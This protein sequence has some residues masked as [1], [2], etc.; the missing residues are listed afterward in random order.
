MISSKEI[1]VVIQ[2]A[3]DKKITP[4]CLKSIRKFLPEAEIILSTWE[5]SDVEGLDY[6]ILV[7]NQDP[8]GY[9]H[10]F[11]IYNAPHH[12]MNNFNRQLVS[13]LN[14]IKKVNR[15]YILKLRTDLI[16]TNSK[17]LSYWDLFE[18]RNSKYAVFN[19][20]VICSSIYSRENSCQSGTGFPTPFHPSDFWF[21]GLAKDLTEYFIN[22]QLQTETEAS[23]WNFKY[24]TRCPYI[25]QLWR[26]SPEQYFC[27]NWVKKYY[28]DLQFE[29]W[30]DWNPQNIELSKNILYNNFVFLGYE[31]SGIYS[32]KHFG[33]ERI[34][35]SIQGLI[36]YELF[37][38]RYKEYCDN[39][40]VVSK[41]LSSSY[42]K[43]KK[44]F[45]KLITPFSKIYTWIG[46]I[47]SVLFYLFVCVSQLL[48][49]RNK[50]DK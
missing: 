6:D 49:G 47:F 45:D 2:G 43:L 46:E 11:A 35:S 40:Y 20:R 4:K 28:P 22:S 19:H 8:G 33:A 50:N 32:K 23:F 48:K 38:K 37:Q 39:T 12:S 41:N 10:D 7:L 13:T 5:N 14:G 3:L 24:P 42:A 25:T 21:L 27:V 17:I 34:K 29:D 9:K 30:S 15:K 18:S 44:H 36:T 31:E 1:S 16:L 26:F